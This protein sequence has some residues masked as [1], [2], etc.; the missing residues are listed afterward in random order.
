MQLPL[1]AAQ[2]SAS[3][4]LS[5]GDTPGHLPPKQEDGQ[6]DKGDTVKRK[7]PPMEARVG[8]TLWPNPAAEATRAAAAEAAP[9]PSASGEPQ[10]LK[11]TPSG[12]AARALHLAAARCGSAYAYGLE[13]VM[14]LRAEARCGGGAD[15]HRW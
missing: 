6:T 7:L 13:L 10:G 12:C 5:G 1:H 3:G 14:R 11:H 4:A 9:G 15:F 2:A 8:P